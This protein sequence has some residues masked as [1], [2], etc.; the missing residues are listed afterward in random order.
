L[1][2]W[3]WSVERT[4]IAA[5]VAVAVACACGSSFSA[6]SKDDAG[7]DAAADVTA[8]DAGD[9]L[10]VLTPPDGASVEAGTDAKDAASD[11]PC[12]DGMK[13][14]NG[15]CVISDDP[16]GPYG[17]F[18]NQCSNIGD[19]T[20]CGRPGHVFACGN[21]NATSQ[22]CMNCQCVINCTDPYMHCDGGPELGCE[23]N[24]GNDPSNCGRC[25]HVCDSGLCVNKACQ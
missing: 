17:C 15:M 7:T 5:A 22:Q 14:C 3:T 10:G 2:V 12:N 11:G 21:A 24:T 6:S 20:M 13:R 16:A 4:C 18:P 9:E 23:T 1:A 25:G 19:P 8:G